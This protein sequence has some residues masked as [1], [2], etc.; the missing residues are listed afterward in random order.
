MS[1]NDAY[2]AYIHRFFR[3]WLPVYD[4]F[5]LSIF[6]VYGTAMRVV[7]PRPGLRV[8]DVC[9]GTGE[10]AL[11]CAR[12]GADVTG[13]DVTP[14]MLEKARRKARALPVRLECLDARRLPFGEREFDVAVLSLALHDMPRRVR[15]EVLR[16]AARVA[17]ERL[18]IVEY[19]FRG[20]PLVRRVLVRLVASFETAYLPRF[21]AEGVEPLLAEAGIQRP[22]TVLR[23]FPVFAVYV[24]HLAEHEACIPS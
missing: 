10:I 20:A 19:A 21:A 17:R 11:R 24:V 13:V 23:Q 14:E 18:V 4:L 9:T 16:E 2:I 3:F 8:L 22:V 5:A 1:A 12:R 7:A 6:W 15:L